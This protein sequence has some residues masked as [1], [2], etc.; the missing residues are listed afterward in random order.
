[1]TLSDAVD[2]PRLH[3]QLLPNYVTVESDFPSLYINGLE[4]RHH[5]VKKTGPLATVQAIYKENGVIYAASDRRKGG[6]PSGY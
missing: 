4:Q 2:I 6:Q 5:I 3:H 1:M